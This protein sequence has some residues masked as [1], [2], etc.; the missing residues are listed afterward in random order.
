MAPAGIPKIEVCF[1]VDANGLLRVRATDGAT[2]KTT[3]LQCSELVLS[4]KQLNKYHL[5]VQNWIRE[6]RAQ[7]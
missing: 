2:K 7:Y 3:E 4:E 6:R 5:L 1:E